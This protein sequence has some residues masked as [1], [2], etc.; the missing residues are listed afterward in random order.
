[1]DEAAAVKRSMERI[2]H[3]YERDLASLEGVFAKKNAKLEAVYVKKDAEL[4][5]VYVTKHAELDARLAEQNAKEV[6]L[7]SIV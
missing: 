7:V 3:N 5:S 1:M 4:E 6:Q 2:I